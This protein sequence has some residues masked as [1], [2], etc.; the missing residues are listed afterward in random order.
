MATEC[1]YRESTE[2]RGENCRETDAAGNHTGGPEVGNARLR[3][4]VAHELGGCGAVVDDENSGHKAMAAQPHAVVMW[5]V[6]GG[7]V[8]S[9]QTADGGGDEKSGAGLAAVEYDPTGKRQEGIAR[10]GS[11]QALAMVAMLAAVSGLHCEDHD[12]I[13]AWKNLGTCSKRL[14]GC[15]PGAGESLGLSRLGWRLRR[16]WTKV[17]VAGARAAHDR[18]LRTTLGLEQRTVEERQEAWR[19]L[20]LGQEITGGAG[21][22]DCADQG[23]PSAGGHSLAGLR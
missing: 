1:N 17:N 13:R 18:L 14:A 4:P 21:E 10:G 11:E 7:M 16:W 8:Q 3:R 6:R 23:P 12:S 22:K 5:M 20:I 9:A 15:A 19:G 2:G